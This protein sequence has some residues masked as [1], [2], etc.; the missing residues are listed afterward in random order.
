MDFFR[1]LLAQFP[2]TEEVTNGKV[3]VRY[4][5]DMNTTLDVCPQH[6]MC[7]QGWKSPGETA[8]IYHATDLRV[9]VQPGR[10]CAGSKGI[11]NDKTMFTSTNGHGG[12]FGVFGHGSTQQASMCMTREVG[13]C[14]LELEANYLL[15]VRGGM[16]NRWV[17]P[18]FPNTP[19]RHCRLQAIWV[20][21]ESARPVLQPRAPRPL[22]MDPVPQQP[23][24]PGMACRGLHSYAGLEHAEGCGGLEGGYLAV[25]AGDV[26][27][28]VGGEEGGHAGNTFETYIF[29]ECQGNRGWCPSI[30]LAPLPS[31]VSMR[32]ALVRGLQSA[33][34]Y[35]GQVLPIVGRQ[36]SRLLL[37]ASD[38]LLAVRE[39]KCTVFYHDEAQRLPKRRKH[40]LL[41]LHPDH[42]GD[43]ELF[44]LLL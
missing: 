35:N 25:K 11:L 27:H 24:L 28:I 12:R 21:G 2:C 15:A 18:G 43:Q 38:R 44:R 37:K 9:L 16:R 8:C 32:W 23:F 22:I 29:G 14:F 31:H 34:Q 40:L 20:R 13:A 39:E 7:M 19:N 36:G 26:V 4:V 33:A 42:K 1:N 41:R 6:F 10:C 30:L 3:F 5:V 17:A